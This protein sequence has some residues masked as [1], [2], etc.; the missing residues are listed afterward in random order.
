MYNTKIPWTDSTLNLVSGCTHAGSPGCD[1]C[2]ARAI[3]TRFSG[4]KA[5]PD[6]FKVTIHQDR[7]LIPFL[8]QKPR[9]VFIC[10][11]GDLFH[12]LVSWNFLDK[13]FAM[14]AL[15]GQHRYLVLT[16]RAKQMKAYMTDI[17]TPVRVGRYMNVSSNHDMAQWFVNDVVWPL[18]NVFLGITAENQEWFD[19]RWDFL[20]YTPAS[21]YFVSHE[22]ALGPIS[23]PHDFLALGGRVQIIC[24][25]ESGT[26]ARPMDLNW[27]R[28]DRDQ[29]I[30]N[31][32]IFFFK[33]C[34]INGKLVETPD[35]DGRKWVETIG[36]GK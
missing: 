33:Q 17:Q 29:C 8:W 10:S 7:L 23:Y 26:K 31:N 15:T 24:G 13:A 35:L 18:P 9:S 28:L 16:K 11:M 34:R 36:R 3:A 25:C 19:K 30:A 27:A 4:T 14:M 6:G 2:Y 32:C 20:K 5:F 12:P 21:G 1:S 22:P